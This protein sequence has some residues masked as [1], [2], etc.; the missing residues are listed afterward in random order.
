[1][2]YFHLSASVAKAL[3]ESRKKQKFVKVERVADRSVRKIPISGANTVA[4]LIG[5]YVQGTSQTASDVVLY[6]YRN[7]RKVNLEDDDEIPKDSRIFC[8][9]KSQAES[10]MP[11]TWSVPSVSSDPKSLPT[12]AL[13]AIDDTLS[14]PSIRSSKCSQSVASSEPIELS[15]EQVAQEVGMAPP[16]PMSYR[17][18]E[19]KAAP[20]QPA[21]W[22]PAQKLERSRRSG[23]TSTSEMS[24]E[25]KEIS[26]SLLEEKCA[27]PAPPKI[28][29]TDSI[30]AKLSLKQRLLL[31]E[32][33]SAGTLT[34]QELES[35]V[36]SSE[37]RNPIRTI[38][39]SIQ[40]FFSHGPLQ[41]P[42]PA[43]QPQPA[44][45]PPSVQGSEKPDSSIV[46]EQPPPSLESGSGK[47]PEKEGASRCV[48]APLA[49]G[50]LVENKED[51]ESLPSP[52]TVK[53][54]E[55]AK[56]IKQSQEVL[57]ERLCED[58]KEDVAHPNLPPLPDKKAP[59]LEPE[60]DLATW[61]IKLSK[62]EK[63]AIIGQVAKRI[64]DIQTAHAIRMSEM[65]NTHRAIV[66]ELRETVM[67]QENALVDYSEMLKQHKRSL[68][69]AFEAGFDK[70][71]KSFDDGIE[72][73]N[74]E[75]A[76]S[77][78]EY[79]ETRF[80]Q[81]RELSEVLKDTMK[82][83]TQDACDRVR[84]SG[85]SVDLDLMSSV[86]RAP[87]RSRSRGK[88]FKDALEATF[89][90]PPES[91]A[92][93]IVKQGDHFSLKVKLKNSDTHPL[94]ATLML[95]TQGSVNDET[96]TLILSH[97]TFEIHLNPGEVHM[98]EVSCQIPMDMK[99]NQYEFMFQILEKR[100]KTALGPALIHPVT[101]KTSE[102]A[103]LD[104]QKEEKLQNL[105]AL[106]DMNRSV[107]VGVLE[108]CKWNQQAA[109][110]SLLEL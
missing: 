78:S 17:E 11:G 106:T 28:L 39:Q 69:Q 64:D 92:Q 3:K 85:Q 105:V 37:P 19:L 101:V 54:N 46:C 26:Q 22:V 12:G 2:Q 108:T 16:V 74:K 47:K 36:K 81:V 79:S 91:L 76:D 96:Q 56:E 87:P 25:Y 45:Q 40:S 49:R 88:S 63:H 86:E 24:E 93:T 58:E 32:K 6:V 100:T 80:K 53:S 14:V 75:M 99:E 9:S 67:R 72:K 33:M 82:K 5:A 42:P 29:L 103:L 23:F 31:A 57:F 20:E 34:Y 10:P 4:D 50:A 1:M 89:Y 110:N 44:V 27:E 59:E 13:D 61:L 30:C 38:F 66:K 94:N 35:V 97:N 8:E 65:E 77:I 90:W 84:S 62:L 107:V 98:A 51:I 95:E 48:F 55:P 15:P 60:A 70:M 7:S 102:P 43:N 71:Q 68:V 73:A 41:A 104:P 109:A 83:K 18:V 52:K 21:T